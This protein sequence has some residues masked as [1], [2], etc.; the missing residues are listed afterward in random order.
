MVRLAV[1]RDVKDRQ[2]LG[3]SWESYFKLAKDVALMIPQTA[4][5]PGGLP[6]PK[7]MTEDGVTISYYPLPI[8]TGDLLPNIATTDTTMVMS[9]SQKFSIDLCKTASKPAASGQTP[10]ALDVRIQTR[11]A[12]DFLDKWIAIAVA[13]PDL[14]FPGNPAKAQKFKKSQPMISALIQSMRSVSGF[15]SKVFEENGQRRTTTRI[16]WKE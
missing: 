11:P 10:L 12:C 16:D 15:E 2:L 1:I 13:N 4:Q 5:L 3:K 14:I 7:S 6:G 9:T 8:P